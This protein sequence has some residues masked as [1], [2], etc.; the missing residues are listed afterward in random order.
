[1]ADIE[2]PDEAVEAAARAD[3]AHGCIADEP[4]WGSLSDDDR[5]TYRA[6]ARVYLAAAAPL[7]V[8]HYLR[9]RK[10]ATDDRP[11]AE[12]FAAFNAALASRYD[13]RPEADVL[14]AELATERHWVDRAASV[15]RYV[16]AGRSY[17]DVEPYP[18]AAARALLGELERGGDR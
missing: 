16:S 14:A 5:R 15:L 18:E 3:H 6:A 4:Y 17:V 13:D 12:E 2:I 7:I 11:T 10:S 1:M 8:E 9:S